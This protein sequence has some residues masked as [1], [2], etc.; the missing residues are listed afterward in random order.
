MDKN[1]RS[2]WQVRIAVILIFVLGFLAGALALNVYQKWRTGAQAH[3][4]E[5]DQMVDRLQLN[6]DQKTLVQQIF[7]DARSQLQ[8]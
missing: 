2:K 6:G 3:R 8:A 1:N 4:Q 7:S 5:F